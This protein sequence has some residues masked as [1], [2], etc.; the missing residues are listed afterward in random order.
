MP[1]HGQGPDNNQYMRYKL[2]YCN[3]FARLVRKLVP[4]QTTHI[5]VQSLFRIWEGIASPSCFSL[6]FSSPFYHLVNANPGGGE[7]EEEGE[8]E[9]AEGG[10]GEASSVGE[11]G[12]TLLPMTADQEP[13]PPRPRPPPPHQYSHQLELVGDINLCFI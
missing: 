8:E 11:G 3:C 12:A 2:Y 10:D 4:L 13:Q 9:G 6:F 7:E 5:L 1:Q